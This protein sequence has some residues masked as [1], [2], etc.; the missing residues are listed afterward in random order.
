MLISALKETEMV[1][2]GLCVYVGAGG[3][4]GSS[5]ADTV[6]CSDISHHQGSNDGL[7]Y[8]EIYPF[9]PE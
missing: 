2:I 6:L 7:G 3:G 9:K 4:G 1:E 8:I 5:Y